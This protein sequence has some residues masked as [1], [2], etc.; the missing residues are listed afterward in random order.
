MEKRTILSKGKKLSM[1]SFAMAAFATLGVAGLASS[2]ATAEESEATFAMENGASV[3]M[4]ES[5][6][7]IRWA[8]TVSASWASQNLAGA[9]N[10][11]F[12]TLIAPVANLD[13]EG[14]DFETEGVIDAKALSF[15][16]STETDSV[17]YSAVRFDNFVEDYQAQ[18]PNKY[19][20]EQILDM[21]YKMELT[22]LSYVTIDGV[23]TYA[24][25]EDVTRS[26]Q[27]VANAAVLA[28]ETK[29]K[30]DTVVARVNGYV[31][32]STPER[33]EHTGVCNELI[34]LSEQTNTLDVDYTPDGE[35]EVVFGAKP[36]NVTLENG[37]ITL[38]GVLDLE[39][40]EQY[41]SIFDESGVH[42][43][44]YIAA[45]KV[46]DQPSELSVFD[47]D[48]NA[49]TLG[50]YYVLSQNINA[51]GYEHSNMNNEVETRAFT[52]TFNGNGYT[53]SNLTLSGYSFFGYT[54]DA[55]IKN[56]GFTNVI[57]KYNFC[58]TLA[59]YVMTTTVENVYLHAENIPERSTSANARRGM[60]AHKIKNSKFVNVVVEIDEFANLE[61]SQNNL[62]SFLS[63]NE[64]QNYGGYSVSSTYQY[65]WKNV[66]VLSDAPLYKKE[67]VNLI[68]AENQSMVSGIQ[69]KDI[70]RYNNRGQMENLEVKPD[71]SDFDSIYWE[72][73]S[74]SPIW[75]IAGEKL[76]FNSCVVKTL[77]QS[78]PTID[79]SDVFA[80]YNLTE[81]VSVATVEEG[82]TAEYVNGALVLKKDGV[83]M[84]ADGENHGVIFY[85]ENYG[86]RIDFKLYTKVIHDATDL[87]I[88]DNDERTTTLDGYYILGGPIDASKYVHQIT[89]INDDMTKA[90]TGTFDGDGYTISGLTIKGGGIFGNLDNATIKNIAFVDTVF[91]AGNFYLLGYRINQSSLNNLYIQA[92]T[93]PVG[94]SSKWANRAIVG[95]EIWSSILSNFVVEVGEFTGLDTSGGQIGSF[96]SLYK[97]YQ[98]NSSAYNN[99][100]YALKWSN[101]YVFSNVPL[102]TYG[103]GRNYITDAENKASVTSATATYYDVYRYDNRKEMEDLTEKEK[104]DLGSFDKAYWETTSG[105]P[106]WKTKA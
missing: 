15:T 33:K 8:T 56:V 106:V 27:H 97:A 78:A 19:T 71:L 102:T 49:G 32:D 60:V 54:K 57:F 38:S 87:A 58:N 93:V 66:Y 22:A 74:G 105:S 79:V 35:Y 76:V 92:D 11:Q 82:V 63:Y 23:T 21:L 7:G 9:E 83:E 12:G 31:C 88:F 99:D 6:G 17:Y 101:V 43:F 47:T 52:G 20:D 37:V 104:P 68:D 28:G 24:T 65:R 2:P 94:G 77:D 50:G 13:S 72:T 61:T 41:V 90:F 103:S 55:T 67:N 48:N 89:A 95:A 1:L 73:V 45:N 59:S 40:G 26:A 53:I 96:L 69:Y 85:G 5:Y 75:K 39:A 70:Y 64:N 51:T 80:K 14:L 34:D 16:A 25:A 98:N 4:M 36:I 91:N 46:I 84:V 42:S 29:G 30:A 10:V 86:V 18:Y 44:P 3:S 100:G 81:V 62:G